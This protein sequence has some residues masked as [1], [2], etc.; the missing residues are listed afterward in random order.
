MREDKHIQSID[1]ISESEIEHESQYRNFPYKVFEVFPMI[2]VFNLTRPFANSFVTK[3]LPFESTAPIVYFDKVLYGNMDR[4][5]GIDYCI[6][7]LPQTIHYKPGGSGNDHHDGDHVKHL[8]KESINTSINQI[9]S[10][11]KCNNC[12]NQNR[13]DPRHPG[14]NQGSLCAETP[15]SKDICIV[16]QDD[17]VINHN[18]N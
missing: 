17:P 8:P 13:P 3:P 15:F 18:T 4:F 16:N 10:S 2:I 6:F 12:C 11:N 5:T 7:C 9:D 1:Q 14:D